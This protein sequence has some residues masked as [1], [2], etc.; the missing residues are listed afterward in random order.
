MINIK[1]A[2]ASINSDSNFNGCTGSDYYYNLF[3]NMDITFTPE[4]I[5]KIGIVPHRVLLGYGQVLIRCILYSMSMTE[6]RLIAKIDPMTLTSLDKGVKNAILGL[7]FRL[8]QKRVPINMDIQ[9]EVSGFKKHNSGGLYLVHLNFLEKP[10]D[11]LI[12][13]IG[14]YLESQTISSKRKEERIV[15]NSDTTDSVNL[16][17]DTVSDPL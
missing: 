3:C 16:K 2:S 5:C 13:I 6:A 1:T 12:L 17:T 10:A 4:V 8:P 11:D 15:I 9:S 14:K 7:A